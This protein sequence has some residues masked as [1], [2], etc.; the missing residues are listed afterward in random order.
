MSKLPILNITET[1]PTPLLK[2]F[3]VFI[4]YLRSHYGVNPI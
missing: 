3:T 4:Q 1:K 2:D